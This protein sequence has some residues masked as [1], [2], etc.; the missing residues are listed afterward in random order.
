MGSAIF[1][2]K[3]VKYTFHWFQF[4]L[5]LYNLK[6]YFIL[7]CK[8][9]C[10]SLCIFT[11]ALC[12]GDSKRDQG[13]HPWNFKDK[14]KNI[15]FFLWNLWVNVILVN[16]LQN[17]YTNQPIFPDHGLYFMPHVLAHTVGKKRAPYLPCV[18]NPSEIWV[19]EKIQRQY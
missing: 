5:E 17:Q 9:A 6:V 14:T 19:R 11:T 15:F 10:F 7:K 8:N 18:W 3:A 1:R 4:V 12:R 16:V 13:R 2:Y